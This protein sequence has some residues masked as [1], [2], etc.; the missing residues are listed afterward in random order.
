MTDELIEVKDYYANGVCRIHYFRN[1]VTNTCEGEYK[2][3]HPNG[4]L[5]EHSFYYNNRLEG[6]HREWFDNGQMRFHAYFRDYKWHGEFKEWNKFGVLVQ[7][8]F[9]INDVC[10]GEYK[11]WN[12]QGSLDEHCFFRDGEDITEQAMKY[13]DD[14]IMYALV[15]GLPRCK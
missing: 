11:T 6:E 1:P 3:W 7:H 4:Q 14:P 2:T 9:Y 15:I 12:N 13:I 10:H 5:D 8:T